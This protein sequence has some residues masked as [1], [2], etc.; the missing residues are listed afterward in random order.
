[1]SDLTFLL[2]LAQPFLLSKFE[3]KLFIIL[4]FLTLQ[5]GFK[6]ERDTPSCAG[7]GAGLPLKMKKAGKASGSEGHFYCTACAKVGRKAKQF[8]FT[9]C[10][11]SQP[12]Y[13]FT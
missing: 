9:G 13:H 3:S 2:F 8:H 12:S 1:M 4:I 11:I 10:I 7:C 6:K 5:N